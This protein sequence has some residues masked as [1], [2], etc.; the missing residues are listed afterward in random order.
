MKNTDNFTE[1]TEG[2]RREVQSTK[3]GS[4][5]LELF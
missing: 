5:L 3:S 1:Y 4:F 2:T